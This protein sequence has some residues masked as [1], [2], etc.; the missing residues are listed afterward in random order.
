MHMHLRI[1]TASP[2]VLYVH[3]SWTPF[4]HTVAVMLVIF[5][6]FFTF[7]LTCLFKFEL[8]ACPLASSWTYF[9]KPAVGSQVPQCSITRLSTIHLPLEHHVEIRWPH[10]T[11]P[12]YF[13]YWILSALNLYLLSAHC[14][15][16][17]KIGGGVISRG[18]HHGRV[19]SN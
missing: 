5:L 13:P 11:S 12:R 17:W 14:W 16:Y 2:M 8:S 10:W 6:H 7:H 9:V 15:A 4:S 3:Q 19:V 1:W 18:G